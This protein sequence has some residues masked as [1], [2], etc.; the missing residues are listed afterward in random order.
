LTLH[1]GFLPAAVEGDMKI[2]ETELAGVKI[3]EQ[4]RRMDNRGY[5]ARVFCDQ[6]F[7]SNQMVTNVA[8]MSVSFNER[9]G[10]L[11]GL[12]FQYPPAS[13]TKYVRC[14]RGAML[15]VI[16]DVR[17]ESITYLRHLGVM[18][19]AANGRALYVPGRFAHGFITLTDQTEVEYTM[20]RPHE[21]ALE[22]GLRYN[23]PG[24][25]IVW[26]IPVSI[27]AERDT[28]WPLLA[29]IGDHVASRMRYPESLDRS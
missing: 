15:D 28:N 4:E 16:V 25:A 26:P 6:L 5:F 12:H 29:A 27:I 2:F 21:P 23:D 24:L 19:S 18:L 10:T 20:N 7:A 9:R 13:E 11:R 22:G 17:P 8:Q 14:V 1:C 3:V